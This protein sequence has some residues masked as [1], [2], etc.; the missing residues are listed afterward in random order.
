[1]R[2]THK[3]SLIKAVGYKGGSV[4]LLALLSWIFTQDLVKMS[5]ITIVYQAV[6]IVG[7][8]IYERVWEHISWG[9]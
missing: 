8:Y 3:R 7:Y 6:T 1:M 9:K 4:A 2:D 5:L